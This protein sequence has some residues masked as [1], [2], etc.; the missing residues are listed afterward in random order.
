[1]S[2][3]REIL[4]E[5]PEELEGERLDRALAGLIEDRSRARIQKD[6]E[7]GAITV[8]GAQPARGAKTPV[9]TGDQIK[10]LPSAPEPLNLVAENIPLDIIFEDEHFLVVN[11]AVGMVVHPAPGHPRGTLVNAVLYHV[12][13]L[14][15]QPDDLRPGI[16]HRLDR[17]TSGVIVVAKTPNCHEGLSDLFK[18]REVKKTYQCVTRGTPKPAKDIIDTWYGRH[19]MDRKR[20]SSK[21][22]RGKRAVTHYEVLENYRCAAFV[23][24][25]LQTGRT[26]QIRVHLTDKG[27]PLVGDDTYGRNKPVYHPDTSQPL[28]VFERPALHACKLAFEHPITKEAVVFEAPLPPDFEHL[29]HTLRNIV[30]GSK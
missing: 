17:D 8:N 16:V 9:R 13:E 22:H 19:P 3:P 27:H 18:A 30:P 4:I 21:V 28:I 12:K 20:F 5:I 14:E 1:M 25:E 15:T 11:K 29:L 26:H 2:E 10:Y 23:Q 6:L 7:A 24:I